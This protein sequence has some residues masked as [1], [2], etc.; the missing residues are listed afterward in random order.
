MEKT[1]EQMIAHIQMLRNNG[2]HSM[3][4]EVVWAI[5]NM[6]KGDNSDGHIHR[7]KGWTRSDFQAVLDRLKQ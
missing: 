2:F 1:V 4:D 7:Y 5:E 3:A 6:A